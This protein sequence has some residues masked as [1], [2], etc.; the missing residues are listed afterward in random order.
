[1]SRSGEFDSNKKEKKGIVYDEN[2]GRLYF[3]CIEP[4]G[5]G[6]RKSPAMDDRC[7]GNL[8]VYNSEIVVGTLTKD[9]E[10]ICIV[11]SKDEKQNG[12][13]LPMTEP[14]DDMFF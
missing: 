7:E 2:D 1:M 10:W 5:V 6:C 14:G 9:G 13:F 4:N 8:G 3:V 11:E 12:T